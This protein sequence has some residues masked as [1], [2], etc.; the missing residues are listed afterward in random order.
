MSIHERPQQTDARIA[1]REVSKLAF[2]T[3]GMRRIGRCK[4]GSTMCRNKLPEQHR[5]QGRSKLSTSILRS[6]R[7]IAALDWR[8]GWKDPRARTPASLPT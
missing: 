2:G 8:R 6:L 5:Q 1:R 3:M 4:R 7:C